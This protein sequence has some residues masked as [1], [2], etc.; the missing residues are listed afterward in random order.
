MKKEKRK[1]K[2]REREE[3]RKR[4]MKQERESEEDR[5]KNTSGLGLNSQASPPASFQ[6]QKDGGRGGSRR[7]DPG[8]LQGHCIIKR[9]GTFLPE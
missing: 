5:L 8:P 4:Q 6:L 7:A 3:M 1:R 9:K 2:N